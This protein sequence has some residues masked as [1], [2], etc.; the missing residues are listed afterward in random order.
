MRFNGRNEAVLD[1]WN[2]DGVGMQHLLGRGMGLD[3][4]AFDPHGVGG[5]I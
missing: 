3:S 2:R 1:Y 4:V 5:R